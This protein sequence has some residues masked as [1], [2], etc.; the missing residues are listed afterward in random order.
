[1]ATPRA[2][3]R[4]LLDAPML[5]YLRCKFPDLADDERE[6]RIEETLRFL[7]IAHEC[8][9]PIPVSREIDDVWH[10]LILQTQEYFQL[11][12]RLPTGRYLHHS[13]NHYL[14]WFDPAVG[15]ADDTALGVKMLALYVAN[16]GPFEAPRARHWLL[17]RHLIETRGWSL[18]EMNDWLRA[19]TPA[20]A[21]REEIPTCEP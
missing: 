13:S 4:Q 21:R 8:T 15:E 14:R 19:D 6:L 1:M 5:N 7:F 10:A 11:S 16:F 3:S 18:E 2:L 17:A 12:E 20:P 9:G